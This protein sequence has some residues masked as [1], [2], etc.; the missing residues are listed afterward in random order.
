M[1]REKEV[2]EAESW[3]CRAAGVVDGA[4]EKVSR[5]RR[6]EVDCLRRELKIEF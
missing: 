5:S 3:P 4:E 6:M 1:V 2:R